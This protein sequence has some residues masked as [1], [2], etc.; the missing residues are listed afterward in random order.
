M[1]HAGMPEEAYS[2]AL[3]AP[4]REKLN[5]RKFGFHGLSYQYV[6]GRAA[7]LLGRPVGELAL[8]IA[9]LGREGSSVVAVKG[10]RAST[11]P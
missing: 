2:Y 7:E 5:L 1:F 10:A 8:I 4:I 11:P 9:H 6:S 3:P